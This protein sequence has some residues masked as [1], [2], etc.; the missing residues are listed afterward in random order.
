MHRTAIL[1]LLLFT[2]LSPFTAL[3]QDHPTMDTVVGRGLDG[4]PLDIFGVAAEMATAIT[5]QKGHKLD[6]AQQMVGLMYLTSPALHGGK[7]QVDGLVEVLTGNRSNSAIILQEAG[8]RLGLAS[9]QRDASGQP[10]PEVFDAR[11]LH[12]SGMATINRVTRHYARG[13]TTR[14]RDLAKEQLMT[15]MR[16]HQQSDTKGKVTKKSTPVEMPTDTILLDPN[17]PIYAQ[18]ET[19]MADRGTLRRS[20]RGYAILTHVSSPSWRPWH[21]YQEVRDAVVAKHNTPKAMAEAH[22]EFSRAYLL[23]L[24]DL[25]LAPTDRL[26]YLNLFLHDHSLRRGPMSARGIMRNVVTGN[27]PRRMLPHIALLAESFELA[28][29]QSRGPI[30]GAASRRAGRQLVARDMVALYQ[31][32]AP[33]LLK[34]ELL[35]NMGQLDAERQLEKL[36]VIARGLGVEQEALGNFKPGEAFVPRSGLFGSVVEVGRA[37]RVLPRPKH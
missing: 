27:A 19:N 6:S 10:R 16:I 18:L 5:S 37:M 3:A 17:V 35:E 2:A 14:G 32:F 15:A 20:L 25:R 29:A 30:P 4:K 1:F 7:A 12:N 33:H 24:A 13:E 11:A 26:P 28:A 36:R 34:A 9:M 8:R 31:D 22:I 23:L 21:G